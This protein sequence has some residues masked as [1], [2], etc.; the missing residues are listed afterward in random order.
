MFLQAGRSRPVAVGEVFLGF[1]KN[2]KPL[3][4]GYLAVA[5]LVGVCMIPYNVVN[6][7]KVLP[8]VEQLQHTPP[9]EV[10]NL[11][12]Q[13]WS[14]IFA[15]LPI[16]FICLI[17]V[18]YLSVNLQFTLPLIVD[19]EMAFLPAMKASWK[20]VHKHW[21]HVFG[22]TVVVGLV[23]VAGLLGC[24]IGI[25][26]TIP[27]GLATMLTAYETIFGTGKK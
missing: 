25:L 7:L 5:L 1:Q 26:F 18:T 16:L 9:T 20:M 17:P 4:L 6:D 13:F 23:S 10:Q 2:F 8:V 19:K 24:C 27:I 21:W 11:L 3:F 12:P 14:A 22:L 15:T